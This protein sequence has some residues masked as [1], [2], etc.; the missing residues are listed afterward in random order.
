MLTL[1]RKFAKMGVFRVSN[2]YGH[3]NT[4]IG[5]NKFQNIPHRVPK[6]REN[7]FRDVE[8]LFSEK[9]IN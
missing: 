5:Y 6:F 8:K 9:M 1:L 4:P 2:S 7:R 3:M